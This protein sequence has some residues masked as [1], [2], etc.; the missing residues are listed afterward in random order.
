MMISHAPEDA[1]RITAQAILVA[2]ATAHA[3]QPTAD[4]LDDPPPVLRD[5]LGS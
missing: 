1:R 2:D 4:L 5:Y 3:P